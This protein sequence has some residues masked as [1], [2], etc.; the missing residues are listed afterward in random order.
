MGRQL[1]L[2]AYLL[3]K[4]SPM[5]GQGS[6]FVASGGRWQVDPRLLVAIA[7]AESSFGQ[8]TCAPYNA[9]GWGCPNGPYRFE[10]WADGI[11]TVMGRLRHCPQERRH[12][13][14][15]HRQRNAPGYRRTHSPGSRS[16]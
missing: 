8:I 2:D 6:A 14:C 3:S 16:S 13:H 7:G 5:A 1:D 4:G 12:H 10:S 15:H 9:W 11:D